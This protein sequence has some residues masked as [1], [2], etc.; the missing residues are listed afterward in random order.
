MFARAMKLALIL[1]LDVR[2]SLLQVT[3]VG[4]GDAGAPRCHREIHLSLFPSSILTAP[5]LQHSQILRDHVLP[6]GR[7]VSGADL[8]LVQVLAELQELRLELGAGAC[9]VL[10]R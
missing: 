9:R 10:R 3:E 5:L 1:A 7:D 8:H 6:T 4:K 2:S